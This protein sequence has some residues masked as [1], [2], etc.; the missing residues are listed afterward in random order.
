MIFPVA[1]IPVNGVATFTFV[2]DAF[3]SAGKY[4]IKYRLI[5]RPG[6]D[7]FFGEEKRVNFEVKK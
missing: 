7:D 5:K 4:T 2:V 3:P 1:Y 6:V